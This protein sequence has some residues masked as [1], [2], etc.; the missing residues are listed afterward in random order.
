MKRVLCLNIF[1]SSFFAIAAAHASTLVASYSFNN[2]LAADQ[3]GIPSLISVD[4]LGLN[5]FENATLNGTVRP[6]F[7]WQGDAIPSTQQAGLTLDTTGLVQYENY[8]VE[9]TFEFLQA[10][11]AGGG[12]RR[13]IDT[14]NRQSDNGFYV[15]PGNRLQVYPVVT[16]STIFSTPGFHDVLLTNFVNGNQREV[17]AYLDGVLQLQSDTNQL[18]LD[19]PDNPGHILSFFLD[20]VNG[21]A[22]NEFA[23]GEIASLRLYDG[24][25]VPSNSVPEPKTSVLVLGG[26][27]LALIFRKGVSRL[28]S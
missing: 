19:N 13:I 6:V 17:K 5:G 4:P 3:A 14:Q 1:V 20:N 12:W 28:L 27:F 8:S 9:L 23:D 2:T 11:Q 25:V 10:A 26:L 18:N 22:Q 15:D 24:I 16:G 21:P 7:H